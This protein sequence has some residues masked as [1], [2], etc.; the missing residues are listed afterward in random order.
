MYASTHYR[1]P[2]PSDRWRDVFDRVAAERLSTPGILASPMQNVCAA[3]LCSAV[4][5]AFSLSFAALIF[6]GPLSPGLGYGIAVTFLSASVGGFVVA[7]RGSLPFA[8]AGPDSATSAVTA[9]L[10]AA[11]AMRLRAQGVSEHL[12]EPAVMV[13]AL[14]S[15]L[16]GIVLCGLG[17]GRAGRLIR[18]V[19]YPVIG[20]FLGATG[21]L[22]IAGAVQ[23]VT[24]HSLS[25]ANIDALTN[26]GTLAKMDLQFFDAPG[27]AAGQGLLEFPSVFAAQDTPLSVLAVPFTNAAFSTTASVSDQF[28]FTDT[29][30]AAHGSNL[31]TVELLSPGAAQVAPD[32]APGNPHDDESDSQP[33]TAVLDRS[34]DH[35]GPRGEAYGFGHSEGRNASADDSN[36]NFDGPPG[37]ALE[38]AL[39]AGRESHR[40]DDAGQSSAHDATNGHHHSGDEPGPQSV[41][42]VSQFVPPGR[43]AEHTL[44]TGRGSQRDD[45]GQSSAHEATNDHHRAGGTNTS[46]D[47]SGPQSIELPTQFALHTPAHNSRPGLSDGVESS[48]VSSANS[49]GAFEKTGL[50][51]LDPTAD[52]FHFPDAKT[53]GAESNHIHI[54]EANVGA[55]GHNLQTLIDAAAPPDHLLTAATND[56][57]LPT[58]INPMPQADP[59]IVH[60]HH[61][62]A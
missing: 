20:G 34:S 4:T 61:G 23:V 44:E 30:T 41:E 10:A 54:P 57:S 16:A 43:A 59:A 19:P 55:Q 60:S 58:G 32:P 31:H 21:W 28:R 40:D 62:M 49:A 14:G 15:A 3:S 38:H 24:D 9:S 45:S 53:G 50:L 18:F 1:R 46:T 2:A 22:I 48:P 33:P 36:T 5:V 52:Q 42:Q 47:G 26:F 37:R 25:I 39:E 13:M 35:D 29:T 51:R 8:L 7:L 11:L 56:A 12:L 6:S 27:H 17:L